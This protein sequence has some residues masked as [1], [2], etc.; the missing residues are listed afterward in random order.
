MGDTWAA[1][2][3]EGVPRYSL[4]FCDQMEIDKDGVWLHEDAV[5]DAIAKLGA[6]DGLVERL[7]A[8][9]NGMGSFKTNRGDFGLCDDAADRLSVLIAENKAL[10]EANEN[11]GILSAEDVAMYQE[12]I[13]R[14]EAAEAEAAALRAKVA[15]LEGALVEHN[16]LLRSA[17]SIEKREGVDGEIASTNWDAYYNRVAVVLKR[18]HQ[19]A[20]DAR[21]ALTDGGK[22][23]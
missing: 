10:K 2:V 13:A 4:D 5:V 9:A 14:A 22:D 12:A 20:N 3:L 8:C 17:L 7:R 23:E 15:R 6:G 18:H 1:K 21:A 19:T 11:L 16:D